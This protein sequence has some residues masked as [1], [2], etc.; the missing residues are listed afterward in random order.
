MKNLL[1]NAIGSVLFWL[2]LGPSIASAQGNYA[3]NWWS[4]DG[5]GGF[6]SGAGYTL[7]GTIGQP[8]A[9]C[10]TGGNYTLVGGFWSLG[11]AIPACRHPRSR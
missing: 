7:T 9:G 6:S 1:S 2:L 8:D 11:S 10:M 3:I 5:G 4:V